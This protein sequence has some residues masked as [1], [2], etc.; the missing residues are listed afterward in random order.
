MKRQTVLSKHHRSSKHSG[1]RRPWPFLLFFCFL[2]GGLS[3]AA[4]CRWCARDGIRSV[5][6]SFD[7][8]LC[9]QA[10]IRAGY[11]LHRIHN[12]EAEAPCP[13]ATEAGSSMPRISLCH[14]SAAFSCSCRALCASSHVWPRLATSSTLN[15]STPKFCFPAAGG[16]LGSC[17]RQTLFSQ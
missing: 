9:V 14:K 10:Y 6:Q 13:C 16:I 15:A 8:S 12:Q 7:R 2:V 1:N 5:C 17:F 11:L 3:L 4:V